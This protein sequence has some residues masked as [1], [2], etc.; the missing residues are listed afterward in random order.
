MSHV[1]QRIKK[2]DQSDHRISHQVQSGA[3]TCPDVFPAY[4]LWPT[5]DQAHPV[6]LYQMKFF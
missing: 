2:A 6:Q 3:S 5:S 1:L 4:Y